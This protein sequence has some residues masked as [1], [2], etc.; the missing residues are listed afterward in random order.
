MKIRAGI[1]VLGLLLAAAIASPAR[2]ALAGNQVDCGDDPA[3]VI[4]DVGEDYNGTSHP[5]VIYG[6]GDNI[7]NGNGGDDSICVEG[8][9]SVVHGNSGN[10]L[11]EIID[12]GVADLYGDGGNDTIYVFNWG[13]NAWGGSGNDSIYGEDATS[14]DGGSGNDYINAGFIGTIHGGSGGDYFSVGYIGE[15]FGD[16]GNDRVYVYYADSVDCGSGRD[17]YSFFGVSNFTSCE[18]EDTS[19]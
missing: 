4:L 12:G 6:Y 19:P 3:S 18:V 1:A 17:V 7:I 10:D 11:L 13:S 9:G 15:L 16:S 2:P 14:I 8:E 5:D